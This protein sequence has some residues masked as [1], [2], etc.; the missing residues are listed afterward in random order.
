M[1]LHGLLMD[2]FCLFKDSNGYS[3]FFCEGFSIASNLKLAYDYFFWAKV[4]KATFVQGSILGR[5]TSFIFS[6]V[7]RVALLST[8]SYLKRIPGKTSGAKRPE[9][10]ADHSLA[11]SKNSVALVREWTIPKERPSLVGEISANF[12]G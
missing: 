3:Q 9:S 2:G 8:H 12:C 4:A 11:S 6:P 7:S 1:G 10:E 5:S